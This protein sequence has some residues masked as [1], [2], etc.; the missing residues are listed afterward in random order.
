VIDRETFDRMRQRWGSYGSWAV[1][2]EASGWPTSNV[3]D[4]SVLD[5]DAN[6][7]LLSTLRDDVVMVG[8][9]IARPFSEP[10][11]NFHDSYSNAKDYKI[12]YAF[13]DTPYYGAYM[14]DIIKGVA[15]VRSKELLRY[16]KA[17]PSVL[18]DN[19]DLFLEEL[20]DLRSARPMILVFGGD[21]HALARE[22]VPKRAYSRLIRLMHYSNYIS[23]EDYRRKVLDALGT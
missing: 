23:H 7:E 12:R 4:L 22:W 10:F 9:N 1:W 16:L 20:T 13:K 8:L 5:P 18:Q 17:N 3:G 19:I 15:E 6:P 2:A 11:R 14:S 21:A